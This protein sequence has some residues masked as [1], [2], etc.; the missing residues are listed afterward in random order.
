MDTTLDK[1]GQYRKREIIKMVKD[2]FEQDRSPQLILSNY[3][4]PR[5]NFN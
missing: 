2:R 3:R 5:G 1:Q 4:A